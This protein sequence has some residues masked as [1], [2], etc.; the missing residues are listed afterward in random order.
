[1]AKYICDWGN[2]YNPDNPYCYQST[3]L[4]TE[5][6]QDYNDG[7]IGKAHFFVKIHH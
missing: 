7:L 2:M 5:Y 1:M 3:E 4:Y 6:S